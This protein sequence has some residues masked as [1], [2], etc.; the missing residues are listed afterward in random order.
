MIN[1]LIDAY[2]KCGAT[3]KA[4]QVFEY[5]KSPHQSQYD[6]VLQSEIVPKP[7]ARTYNTLLKGLANVGR[8][9]EA[10]ELASEMKGHKM[11]DSVTTNTLVH[12]AVVARDYERAEQLL[13][14]YAVA[15]D[16]IS[17][18]NVEAFTELLDAYAKDLRMDKAVQ[19]MQSMRRQGVE[20]SEITY[21]CLIAGFG[22]CNKV[23]QAKKILSFMANQ[24]VPPSCVTYNA[25][26]SEL[27]KAGFE[28][29][30]RRQ[31]ALSAEDCV[32]EALSLLSL[33]LRSG[34]KPNTVTVSVI[35]SAL[36][37]CS[38][39][40]VQE[41]KALV[42]KLEGDGVIPCGHPTVVSA[43]IR[44]C[45]IAGEVAGV[46]E[47]FRSL[48][49]ADTIAIN[50]FLDASLRCGRDELA[51]ETFDDYFRRKDG[52]VKLLP[53]IVS[54]SILISSLLQKGRASEVKRAQNLYIE[55]RQASG[56]TP[57]TAMIDII[58]R[59]SLRIAS[60]RQ[61]LKGELKFIAIVLKDAEDIEWA[62]GKLE[63]RKRAVHRALAERL[64]G[65]LSNEKE[66]AALFPAKDDANDLFK[67]KGWNKV[68]SGFRLWGP[69]T[70]TED[71]NVK[72]RK[73]KVLDSFLESKGWND[74]DSGFR[75]I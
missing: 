38:P 26:I 15:S 24:G 67:K 51:F 18:P 58:L 3:D 65:V 41:A 13:T 72:T 75:I 33:M 34:V 50:A 35:I 68:D 46:I 20:P 17:H 74:V 52:S 6:G 64:R 60:S 49:R 40:R 32:S 44:A 73:G 59:A 4:L 63:K 47:A 11:W 42:A 7:N 1:S 10:I 54:Y 71:K 23:D 14:D 56:I 57:D 8:L 53:D 9:E 27:V 2:V 36:G 21:T 19:V 16:Q 61:L 5:V 25:L 70:T 31:S 45:G 29:T 12:A 37:R 48:K 28:G 66:F 30:P 55:M 69:R 43:L 62:D 39:P 22:R